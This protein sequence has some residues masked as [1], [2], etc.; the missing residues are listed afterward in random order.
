MLEPVALEQTISI[1]HVVCLQ[2]KRTRALVYPY[3]PRL[4]CLLIPAGDQTTMQFTE[5]I[6]YSCRNFFV[7]SIF[8][9]FVLFTRYFPVNDPQF[10]KDEYTFCQATYSM[11]M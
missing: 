6:N 9:L 5:N 3:M 4:S 7:R 8:L 11:K 1:M 2:D 10:G